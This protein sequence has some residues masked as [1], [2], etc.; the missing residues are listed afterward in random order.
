MSNDHIR[1]SSIEGIKQLAKRFKKSDGIQHAVALDKAS[2]TAGFENYKHALRKLGDGLAAPR[3]S[4]ELYISVLWRD[5]TTKVTGCEILKMPLGRPL[6]AL[7]KPA[8]YKASRG[9]G[10]MRREGPDHLADTY[11]AS[12]QEAAREAACEAARTIQFIEAAQLV[13]S[14]AKRSFPRGQFQHRMPGSDHDAAWFDPAAKIFIRTNEPYA[15]SITREQ[16]EWADRHGWAV[17]ISP[18]KGM[19]RPDGGTSLFLLADMSKGYLLEPILSRLA[20]APAPIVTSAWDGESR[21]IAPAFVSPGQAA[22]IEAR[23]RE[24]KTAGERRGSNNSVPYS[25]FLSGP[26]RRPKTRMPIE[27]HK[28]VGRLL[29]SVLIGTRDR[30][31]VHRRVDAIRCELDNWVQS[32]YRRDELSDDVFFDLYYHELPEGDVLAAVPPSWD[33]HIVNLDDVKATLVRY[34]PECPPLRQLLKKADL[35]IASLRTWNV[36][37]THTGR[38]ESSDINRNRGPDDGGRL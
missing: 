22:E 37:P 35:A 30:A 16:K 18:W 13:P 2:K 7:V 15:H 24:A 31:G 28:L 3:P 6:D 29:K 14:K 26:Q 27:G 12:S 36:V 1:P 11:T 23:A 5:R 17:A 38:L 32:E 33:R 21:P 25:M 9:L 34:Y 10:T 20:E 19:Y 8:Q 4:A